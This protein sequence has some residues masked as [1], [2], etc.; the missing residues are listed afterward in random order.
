MLSTVSFKNGWWEGKMDDWDYG[1][2]HSSEVCA[3]GLL[4]EVQERNS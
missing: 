1:F 3:H 2:C 4:P